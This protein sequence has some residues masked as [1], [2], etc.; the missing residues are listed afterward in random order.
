MTSRSQEFRR[1]YLALNRDTLS[2][3]FLAGIYDRDIVFTDPL[4]RIEGIKALH[5]YFS[6][7]Y[8]N[9]DSID[10]SFTQHYDSANSSMERWT[11]T[12]RHPRLAGGKPIK[13][14]GCSELHWS[15]GRI[16]RHQDFFD[17]GSMLYEHI[18]LMGWG[19]RKLKERLV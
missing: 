3:D 16:V 9:V 10:F 17:A 6:E 5:R 15:N 12:F 1:F 7:M 14:D 13:V 8:A 18:P 11:M 19:I 4:H 2:E